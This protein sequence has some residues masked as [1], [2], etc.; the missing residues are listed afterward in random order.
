VDSIRQS[1]AVLLFVDRAQHQQSDFALTPALAP[2]VAQLCIRLDGIPFALELAAALVYA[3]SIDEINARLNDRFN[4]LTDGSRT[5][6][7]RQQTLRA[8]LDWSHGLL[9]EAERKVLHRVSLFL[10]G[11][12]VGAAAAVA[13]DETIGESAVADL[14]AQLVARSLVVADTT[15]AGTRYRLLETIRAYGREKLD[16][17]GE[18]AAMQRRHA[19]YI[20]DL[21]Q[22]AVDEWLRLPEADWRARYLPEIDNVRAALEWSLGANG[23]TAVAVALAGAS[24]PMWPALTLHGEAAQRLGAA[25]ARVNSGTPVADQARLSFW[26][27]SADEEAM[28]ARAREEFERTVGLYRKLGDRLGLGHST[29]RLAR[30]L[31]TTGRFESSAVALREAW[32]ALEH[33]GAPRLLAVYFNAAG[34]LKMLTGDLVGARTSQ[35]QALALFREGGFTFGTLGALATLADITWALGDLPAAEASFREVIA[36]RRSSP[37]VRKGSLGLN[38]GNLAGVLIERGDVAGALIAAREALPLLSGVGNAWV[39]MEHLAVRLALVGNVANAAR[40][41]GFAA[42]A[43]KTTE[44]QRQP[45]EARAYARL[46]TLLRERLDPGELERLLAEGGTMTEDEACKLALED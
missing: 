32:R 30:L 23:D 46:Y 16:D 1:D 3:H 34:H 26:L 38:L 43:F 45:N 17:T 21:F 28:P 31:A 37:I 20:R 15:V 44:F 14:L 40:V 41:A 35:E 19:Q 22:R 12:T 10:G 2:A 18:T 4:L 8:T 9:S 25:A 29:L 33:S 11:F 42:T 36:M 6:L 5:A 7:P 39:F 27:A 24:G 13:T